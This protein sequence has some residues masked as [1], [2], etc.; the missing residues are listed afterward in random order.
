MVTERPILDLHTDAGQIAA[1]CSRYVNAP[2][3]HLQFERS[4]QELTQVST[5]RGV[6]I[7]GLESSTDPKHLL[8]SALVEGGPNPETDGELIDIFDAL[9]ERAATVAG[10]SIGSSFWNVEGNV[11]EVVEF[12]EDGLG[13][14]DDPLRFATP[15]D[16]HPGLLIFA[17]V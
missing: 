2:A 9:A 12:I 3:L 16:E 5:L 15:S 11:D 7:S 8:M 4:F 14:T 13:R 6:A 10:V 17:R 1:D